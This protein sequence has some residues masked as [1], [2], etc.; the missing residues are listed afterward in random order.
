VDRVTA[1]AELRRALD[2]LIGLGLVFPEGGE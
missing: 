1:E 2:E